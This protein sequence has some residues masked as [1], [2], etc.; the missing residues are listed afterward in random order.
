MFNPMGTNSV[1][2]SET[3]NQYGYHHSEYGLF[4]MSRKKTSRVQ[5]SKVISRKI[6]PSQFIHIFV[7]S[8]YI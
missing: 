5:K 7:I 3:A 1:G 6:L 4:D 2:T 8:L